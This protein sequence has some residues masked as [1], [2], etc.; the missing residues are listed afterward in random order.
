M[1]SDPNP[2]QFR[3][4]GWGNCPKCGYFFKQRDLP[5]CPMC[6]H[7]WRLMVPFEQPAYEHP[8]L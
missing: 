6:R 4:E 1:T 5:N 2:E 3:R 7:A 8:G